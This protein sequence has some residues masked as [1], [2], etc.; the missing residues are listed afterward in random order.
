M[1]DWSTA[2]SSGRGGRAP[3]LVVFSGVRAVDPAVELDATVDIVVEDGRITR[4]GA[5]AATSEMKGSERAVVVEGAG[6]WAL[7][8]FVDI[9]VHLREPGHEYKEDIKSG[10]AAAAAGGFAH[11]CCMPNT[12]PVNDRRSITE[13]MVSRSREVG[14]P[15]LHPIGA[16]TRG[17][18][19]RELTEIGSASWRGRGEI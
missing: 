2:S 13:A 3:Q 4:V 5:G 12:K 1:V 8:A 6:R 14:G 19:G 9:H 15:A 17:L 18:E 11:V 10:L 7:P 16:I